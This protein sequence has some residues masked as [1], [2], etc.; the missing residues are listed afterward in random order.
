MIH[1]KSLPA[2]AFVLGLAAL[3]AASPAHTQSRAADDRVLRVV[4]FADLQSL[5]PIVTTVGI[6][7]RHATMV[8]DFLFGRD[9]N[10]L[11]QPQ[12]VR[13][14]T[15]SADGLVWTFVLRDGL[16]FHDG[17]PVTADDV[18]ASLRRWAARDSNGRQIIQRTVSLEARDARTVVWT[19]NKPY[20]L[21]LQ[22]LS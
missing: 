18:V 6:V 16:A 9:D 22:A 8:Y 7:Q 1:L 15:Q 17:S 19:L 13:S 11:P 12:M 20:G 14:W 3:G 21:M 4:P 10:Q 5:D 2:L